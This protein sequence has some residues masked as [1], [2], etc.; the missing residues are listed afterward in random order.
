MLS[1]A[2]STERE[3]EMVVKLKEYK[4]MLMLVADCYHQSDCFIEEYIQLASIT[5][6]ARR[7]D[8]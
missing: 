4:A 2:H 7:S 1:S 6:I 3:L 5:G 8:S